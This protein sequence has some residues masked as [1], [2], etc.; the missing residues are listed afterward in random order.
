[1]LRWRAAFNL[2]EVFKQ[3]YM[4]TDLEIVKACK[5]GEEKAYKVLVERYAPR[6]MAVALRYLKDTAAAEDAVQE[7][8]IQVFQSI[9]RYEHKD[10][11]Y[12]WLQRIAVNQCLK[13][14]RNK[15]IWLHADEVEEEGNT[16]ENF[17]IRGYEDNLVKALE[18]LPQAYHL[19]FNLYVADGYTH[20]EIA[21]LL[22]ITESTS[23]VYLTRA[24][25]LL[26]SYLSR[27]NTKGYVS[28]IS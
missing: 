17:D 24:R 8:L 7:S 25:S 28:G 10:Q 19:V 9:H 21:E 26:K 5:E 13:M 18:V 14:L 1:M 2:E 6:L 15:V 3:A 22:G 12:P 27:I 23:R 11:L 4:L 16:Y 20:A